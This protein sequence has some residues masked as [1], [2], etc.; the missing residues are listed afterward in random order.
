MTK[1]E[2]I[3]RLIIRTAPPLEKAAAGIAYAEQL[4]KRLTDHGYGA[5]DPT[6][7]RDTKDWYKQLQ[8]EQKRQFDAFWRSFNYKKGRNRAAMRWHQM[9]DIDPASANQIIEAA[10]KEATTPLAPGVARKMAEGWLTEKRWLDHAT[11][12]APKGEENRLRLIDLNNKLKAYKQLNK[13]GK[14]DDQIAAV[15][16]Q[17]EALKSTRH[18]H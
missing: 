11:Q 5:T 6:G 16:R 1:K 4:W 7:P 8:G 3:Q 13:Q 14:L 18:E 15:T 9:G 2:F 17:I 10:A 12:S